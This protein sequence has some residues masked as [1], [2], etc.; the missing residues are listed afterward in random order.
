M[1]S[2]EERHEGQ[3]VTSQGIFV[4]VIL[5]FQIEVCCPLKPGQIP[6]CEIALYLIYIVGM[7]FIL[8]KSRVSD[9][10]FMLIC[11]SCYRYVCLSM[12]GL[13]L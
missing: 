7:Q 11:L 2:K 6:S 1:P 13:L 5:L 9:R 3:Q 4:S 10:H 8:T 12:C